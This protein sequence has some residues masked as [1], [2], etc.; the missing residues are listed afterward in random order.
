M[1]EAEAAI[2][3]V[4]HAD[5]E[6]PAPDSAAAVGEALRRRHG[7]AVGAVLFYGSCLRSG[8]DRDSLL[9]LYLLVDR[10]RDAYPGQALAALANRILP[11]NVFYF[12]MP[13]NGRTVRTKYAV[14]DFDDFAAAATPS[15]LL[16]AVW[17]R[18]SQPTVLLYS[19]DSR[20]RASI[21]EAL[22]RSIATMALRTAP[23]VEGPIDAAGFWI[24][25]YARSY[26][27]EARV[28]GAGRARE[29]VQPLQRYEALLR[30]ALALAAVPFE[31]AGEGRIRTRLSAD[32]R[33]RGLAFWSRAAMA[34]RLHSVPRLAKAAVTFEGGVDYAL[35]KVERHSGVRVEAGPWQRRHP[36]LSAI[37]LA[38]RAWRQGAFRPKSQNPLG[39]G[40]KK[41]AR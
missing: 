40:P 33:A 37:P 21:E 13:W 38:F 6:R 9:D 35:W 7:A 26:R 27:A 1:S 8:S 15:A 12:E 5:W 34:T 4:I 39:P 28:E 10:Y 2:R 3:D 36:I 22:S 14:I 31:E 23:L 41:P 25:G 24:A 32:E 29:L 17:A 19:R 11:P 18:F 30:P 16:P 20:A